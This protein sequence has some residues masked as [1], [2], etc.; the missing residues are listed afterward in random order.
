MLVVWWGRRIDVEEMSI[1]H[2][3]S[4]N[5]GA[6]RSYRLMVARETFTLFGVPVRNLGPRGE[7]LQCDY[8]GA[9]YE[10]GEVQAARPTSVLK[11]QR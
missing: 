9:T 8:C 5:E 3:F 4:P 10:P 11:S 7:Y 6:D 1:G 2:F